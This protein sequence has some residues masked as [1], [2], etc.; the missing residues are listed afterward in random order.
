MVV[1]SISASLRE[2]CPKT[3][4]RI[5]HSR[6]LLLQ[7]DNPTFNRVFYNKFDG[8]D[9]AMLAKAM[10]AVHSLCELVSIHGTTV[11]WE[12]RTIFDSRIPPGER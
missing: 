4:S 5:N 8:F 12:L 9:W 6:L 1:K 3:Y 10:N 7:L 11:G 2:K